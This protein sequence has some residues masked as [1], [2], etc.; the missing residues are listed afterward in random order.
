MVDPGRAN[1]RLRKQ[2]RPNTGLLRKTRFHAALRMVQLS[3]FWRVLE[4]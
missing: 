1:A 4:G 3:R 2:A